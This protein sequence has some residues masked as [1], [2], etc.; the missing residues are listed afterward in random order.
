MSSRALLVPGWGTAPD[1]FGVLASALRERGIDARPWGYSAAGSFETLARRLAF[2]AGAD[3]DPRP[4]HLIGHSLGGLI[5]TAAAIGPMT[6]QVASVTT[7]NAPWRG[8]W[9]GWTAQGPLARSLR[10]G[11]PELEDLRDRLAQHLVEPEGPRWA[12]LASAID[13]GVPATSALRAPSGDRLRKRLLPMTGHTPLD[14]PSLL[15]AVV[16]HVAR[17]PDVVPGEAVR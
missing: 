6:Q 12:V 14:A 4:V 8:T 13:L 1:R 10:W 9:L 15:D 11:A 3:Q 17:H 5:V 7:I 2:A 16:D